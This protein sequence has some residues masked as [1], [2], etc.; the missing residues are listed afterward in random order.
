[1]QVQKTVGH[2]GIMRIVGVIFKG[3][4]L[5]RVETWLDNFAARADDQWVYPAGQHEVVLYIR[6]PKDLKK[7]F[8]TYEYTEL[9][10]ALR[11]EPSIGLFAHINGRYEGTKEATL[12]VTSILKQ[13]EGVAFDEFTNHWWTLDEIVND[14]IIGGFHFFDYLEQYRRSHP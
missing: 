13:F 7:E 1:M 11:V 2:I 14:K 5:D 9:S 6:I 8:E 3:T 10:L 4:S 12:F